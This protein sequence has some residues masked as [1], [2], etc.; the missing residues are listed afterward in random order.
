MK[1][2]GALEKTSSMASR[3]AKIWISGDIAFDLCALEFRKID[4]GELLNSPIIYKKS[5]GL[6]LLYESHN[7]VFKIKMNYLR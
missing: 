5:A 4:T 6:Y 3:N 1:N 7:R 2:L